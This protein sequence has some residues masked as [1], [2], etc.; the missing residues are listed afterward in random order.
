MM[1][2][3]N[4]GRRSD[5]SDADY[6]ALAEFRYL[7]RRFV[8]FSESA[9]RATGLA[10]QQHQALLAIKGYEVGKS[11]TVGDLADRLSIRH[12]SAVGLVD[13]LVRAG[14]VARNTDAKDRRRVTLTLTEEGENIL[15]D[16]SSA[17]RDELRHLTPSLKTLFAKLER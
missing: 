6:K 2:A 5:L 9:A 4:S 8:T 13:R 16:L 17:H 1:T 3:G 14:H 12:N 10:P 15:A 7:I 11:L